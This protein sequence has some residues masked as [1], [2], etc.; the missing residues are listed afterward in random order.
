MALNFFPGRNAACIITGASRGLG[1]AIAKQ[2]AALAIDRMDLILTAR[3]ESDLISLRDEITQ[4]VPQVKVHIVIGSLE[5]QE[6]IASIEDEMRK[7]AE[8]E[9]FDQVVLIHNA[10]S[11]ND[12][13]RL[14]AQNNT[15]LMEE[16]NKY[17]CLNVTSFICLT[18]SFM[19]A[20]PDVQNR[21]IVN[22]SSLAGLQALKGMS[23]YGSAKAA[24]DSVIRSIAHENPDIRCISYA[25]GPLA[26][27][28]AVILSQKGYL[29]EFF[30]NKNNL[31]H[32]ET[33]VKKL[34][35]LLQEN[36]FENGAHIDVYDQ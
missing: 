21:V 1:R 30:E 5:R 18:A 19:S 17:F 25:P 33:T 4:Q 23:V 15:Q 11:L 14:V 34:I 2:F 29:K 32:P 28:M 26:T 7:L 12:P 10:G 13:E 35:Q 6:T 9:V 36:T 24:R 3:T 20:F 27:E 16:L 31:L 22:I 8:E